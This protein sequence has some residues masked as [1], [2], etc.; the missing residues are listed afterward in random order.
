MDVSMLLPILAIALLVIAAS[1]GLLAQH[2]GHRRRATRILAGGLA[3]LAIAGFALSVLDL[4]ASR[5]PLLGSLSI[6][7]MNDTADGL[8]L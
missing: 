8:S 2:M 6:Y 1:L 7:Y 3:L 4:P 5:A